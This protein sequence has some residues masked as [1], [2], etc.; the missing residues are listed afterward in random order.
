[1]SS[2][3]LP[4]VEDVIF[5][6]NCDFT[7]FIS[8]FQV[9]CKKL[10]CIVNNE[11]LKFFSRKDDIPKNIKY[12]HMKENDI[13]EY[14]F[15]NLETL[16]IYCIFGKTA[17]NIFY[18]LLE[19]PKPILISYSNKDVKTVFIYHDDKKYEFPWYN[20]IIEIKELNIF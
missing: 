11:K 12:L 4:L 14:Y 1:M 20:N 19:K 3:T 9:N 8:Q 15:Q 16:D 17:A 6:N 13:D 10:L 5:K 2:F 18:P 7:D